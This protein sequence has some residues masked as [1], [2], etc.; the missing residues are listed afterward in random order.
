[1]AEYDFRDLKRPRYKS[2]VGVAKSDLS[3]T[4][5]TM[6]VTNICT[7]MD[8]SRATVNRDIRGGTLKATKVTYHSGRRGFKYYILQ[9]DFEQYAALKKVKPRA[10]ILTDDEL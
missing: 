6:S 1:M 3:K 7:R 8:I 9:S 2:D 10:K 5:M 4:E